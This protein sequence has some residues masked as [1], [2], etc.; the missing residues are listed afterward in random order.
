M[1]GRLMNVFYFP[2]LLSNLSEWFSSTFSPRV[3]L[4]LHPRV[5]VSW[6]CTHTHTHAFLLKHKDLRVLWL[7][8]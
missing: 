1:I 5:G 2:F 8:A 3:C 6:Y 4:C 7:K